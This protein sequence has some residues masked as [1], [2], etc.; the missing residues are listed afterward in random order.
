M[1]FNENWNIVTT[2]K[3]LIQT[4]PISIMR[5]QFWCSCKLGNLCE[6]DFLL[7]AYLYSVYLPILLP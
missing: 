3:R 7:H 2:F 4:L 6:I 1:M 5:I